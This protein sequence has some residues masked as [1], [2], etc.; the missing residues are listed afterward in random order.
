MMLPGGTRRGQ[1]NWLVIITFGF[2]VRGFSTITAVRIIF[3][4]VGTSLC[5]SVVALGKPAKRWRCLSSIPATI[6]SARVHLR[7]SCL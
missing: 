7:I 2:I 1:S 5:S 3:A 6:Q 4:T